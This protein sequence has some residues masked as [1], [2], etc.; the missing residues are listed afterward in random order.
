MPQ[1]TSLRREIKSL[2]D[3]VRAK[4][5]LRFFKTGPGEYGEGDK[6][7]GLTVPQ[8]RQLARKYKDLSFPDITKLL[9]SE[10]HEERL[11]ALLILVHKFANR[12][13]RGNTQI[14][15]FYLKN[16][17]YINNWDLVDLSAPKIV[18]EYLLNKP[19]DILFKLAKSKSLWERRIAILATFAFIYK[20]DPNPTLQLAETLITDEADLIHKAVGWMLREVGKR[21]S[22]KVLTDF[23]DRNYKS[24]PRTMLRYS[25]ERFPESLR[26]KYL[27]GQV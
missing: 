7:L 20:G 16:T 13:D 3:P 9:H 17:R 2:A 14:S 25:I 1:L 10:F 26:L 18:G 24:M 6:F 4:H 8:C 5:S 15:N 21:C 11:I 19:L 12:T 27:T 22:Q 23:L